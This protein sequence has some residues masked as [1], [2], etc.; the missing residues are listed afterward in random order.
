[1]SRYCDILDAQIISQS[2]GE[3][4]FSVYEFT[5]E[6]VWISFEYMESGEGIT[7]QIL[8]T[9]RM[10]FVRG[11]LILESKIKNGKPIRYY[12][13]I[14]L[15]QEEFKVL[16]N[17]IKVFVSLLIFAGS[18]SVLEFISRAAEM[19][20]EGNQIFISILSICITILLLFVGQKIRK[21]IRNVFHKDM[22]E[23]LKR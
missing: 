19:K 6:E 16:S 9:D 8:H 17:C 15:K 4:S 3:N 13:D 2:T 21:K 20:Y 23:A 7:L 12:D 5:Q 14:R 22:P 11:F 1:M 10:F 18:C